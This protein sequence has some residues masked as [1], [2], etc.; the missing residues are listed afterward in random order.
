MRH[1]G[2]VV[3]KRG[4][5][6]NPK[7]QRQLEIPSYII[8][9]SPCHTFISFLLSI[10][11]KKRAMVVY[12]EQ[13]FPAHDQTTN[14]SDDHQIQSDLNI[15]RELESQGI[16]IT[17]SNGRP[18]RDF[19]GLTKDSKTLAIIHP[20]TAHQISAV[21]RAAVASPTLTVAPCGNAHSIHGQAF[22]HRGIV[23]DMPAMPTSGKVTLAGAGDFADVGAGATWEEVLK[24]CVGEHGMAPRSWTD[25]LGLTVGGTV[26][27]AGVSGQ[28]FRHGPQSSNVME[29][30]V[31]TGNGDVVVCS[32][33]QNSDLFFAVLGGL[34]QFGVITKATIALQPAP[35]TVRW[36]RLVYTE[37]SAF[38]GDAEFLV[39]QPE[40][41][42]FDYVEG[43]V[44][45]NSDDP[46]N[47]WPSVPIG[48]G[49]VFDQAEI[50]RTAGPVL[51]CLELVLHY[52]NKGDDSAS[53]DKIVDVRLQ[54]L[55]YCRDL[56]FEVDVSYVEFLL[57]VKH[58]EQKAV[59]NGTWHTPHPW[60]NLFVSQ[61]DIADFDRLIF[62]KILK[63][64][65][66]G[67]MLVYPLIKSKWD[68]RTSVVLPEG[69][70]FY[71]VALLRFSGPN[72]TGPTVDNMVAQNQEIIRCCA[73]HGFD[74]KLYLPHYRTTEQW[75]AHFGDQWSRFVDRK[76]RFDPMAILAP[77]Q[78][79]F[80]RAH[81][82]YL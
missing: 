78:R 24:R 15:C 36:I 22:A 13:R 52:K 32:E 30:E 14:S 43:F 41:N 28:A 81:P 82:S 60:L 7:R 26:S 16:P 59:A 64:G 3:D 34:G 2:E 65:I 37:F 75:K 12:L 55:R 44:F 61:R 54:R 21:L 46:V 1:L 80:S 72:N 56:R 73:E 5:V 18:D 71:I 67:P 31:V 77:G 57:R 79:I 50:P 70:I 35:T 11:N 76:S 74:F 10:S 33:R 27:N 4:Y 51:Y 9:S 25:Y 47:G 68:S 29:M 42:S 66:G 40:S 69:E 62:K 8:T 53:V 49:Q 58:V 38:A 39:T 48:S 17:T 6:V 23:L 45:V 19:G 20:L 63:D